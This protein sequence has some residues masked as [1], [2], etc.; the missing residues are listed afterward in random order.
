MDM[1]FHLCRDH[2][3]LRETRESLVVMESWLDRETPVPP[4]H[5]DSVDLL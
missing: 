2:K 4:V 1:S 5:P 3:D